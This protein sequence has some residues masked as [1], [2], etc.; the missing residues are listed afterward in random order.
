MK[1]DD[2]GVVGTVVDLD[3]AAMIVHNLADNGQS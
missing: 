2:A 1:A 3:P